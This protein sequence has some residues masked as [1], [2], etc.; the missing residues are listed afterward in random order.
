MQELEDLVRLCISAG[1]LQPWEKYQNIIFIHVYYLFLIQFPSGLYIS[2]YV[3]P[4]LGTM[5]FR[6]MT[7][8]VHAV[9]NTLNSAMYITLRMAGMDNVYETTIKS[10]E[11]RK[12][13]NPYKP[14]IPFVGHSQTVQTKITYH[15]MRRL[16]RISAVCL[17]NVL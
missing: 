7:N 5:W 14:S 16:I 4:D 10:S 8:L 9:L 1:S 6:N 2:D 3:K 12:N 15:I 17:Q 13:V 11:Q